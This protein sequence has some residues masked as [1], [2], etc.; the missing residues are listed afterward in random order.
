VKDPAIGVG[1]EEVGGSVGKGDIFAGRGIADL[2]GV[3]RLEKPV[4]FFPNSRCARASAWRK[5]IASWMTSFVSESPA[6]PS[7]IAA[8][9]SFEEMIA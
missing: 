4:G 7:I 9:I 8:P 3:P 2:R 1:G 5:S 6:G